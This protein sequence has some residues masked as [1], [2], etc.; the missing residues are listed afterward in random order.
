[1]GQWLLA[2]CHTAHFT[3]LGKSKGSQRP[4][5]LIEILPCGRKNGGMEEH[6]LPQQVIELYFVFWNEAAENISSIHFGCD[7]YSG[8]FTVALICN[9]YI[10]V[11][12]NNL[13]FM[14]MH[15][16]KASQLEYRFC[17]KL[18]KCN[19]KLTPI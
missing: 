9:T 19:W 18:L 2:A 11:Y 5:Y 12:Y 13:R 16:A 10:E 15:V 8:I 4:G 7:L 3:F 1:M 17:E 14:S 6:V